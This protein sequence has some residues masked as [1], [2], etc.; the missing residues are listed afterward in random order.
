V[1]RVLL[2]GS[3][4]VLQAGYNLTIT[5]A[6]WYWQGCTDRTHP[7]SAVPAH[8]ASGAASAAGRLDGAGTGSR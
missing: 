1:F 5:G 2:T 6:G 8:V 7:S 3:Q 4:Q